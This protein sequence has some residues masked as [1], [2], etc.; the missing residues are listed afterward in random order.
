MVNKFHPGPCL[1]KQEMGVVDETC[2]T[3]PAETRQQL[4]EYWT[5]PDTYCAREWPSSSWKER[6]VRLSLLHYI[7][8]AFAIF[9][10][11]AALALWTAI[12]LHGPQG[13]YEVLRPSMPQSVQNPPPAMRI[14]PI[15]FNPHF[16]VGA[17]PL[18]GPVA[19]AE[20][21]STIAETEAQ[22]PS[23]IVE[24]QTLSPPSMLST[25]SASPTATQPA[26]AIPEVGPTTT[27]AWMSTTVTPAAPVVKPST[28]YFHPMGS[29]PAGIKRRG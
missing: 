8:L 29:P 16:V 20:N 10:M 9:T 15:Q 18:P 19:E 7:C 4:T 11:G 6:G 27:T 21:T 24:T 28:R 26:V 3:R 14:L 23:T 17:A 25:P 2:R 1:P 13:H 5:Y 22:T 12:V